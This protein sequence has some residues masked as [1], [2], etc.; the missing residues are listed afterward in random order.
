MKVMVVFGTRPE[1]IKMC[2]LILELKSR[3]SIETVVCLSGQHRDLIA[4]IIECFGIKEDYNLDIM[5]RNQTLSDIT[6]GIIEKLKEI[7]INEKPNLVLVHGDT[8]TSFA[9]ALASFYERI[10]VGHVEAGLRTYDRYSP[11]PEEINRQMIA[12]IATFHFAPTKNNRDNLIKEN[13][14]ENVYVTGNTVIDAFKTT[15]KANYIFENDLLNNLDDS[16]KYILLTAHRRENIGQPLINICNAVKKIVNNNKGFN[17]IYPVHPNPK[18]RDIVYS[19]L[20]NN[21]KILLTDPLDVLDMHNLMGKCFLIMTD[22]GGLQEEAPA[23]KKPVVVLRKETERPEAIESG[24]A[25]LAGIEEDKIY[26]TVIDIIN[27]SEIYGK[28]SNAENPYGDGNASKR[29]ADI[30]NETI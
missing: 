10:P 29:I 26:N 5:K 17:V 4:P 8:T 18:V 1:A 23:L 28:M 27:N 6:T 15:I 3:L 13:I 12:R 22:S 7:L 30:L 9:A 2:P 21:E 25:V 20:G 19:I 14:K 16:N 24:T 11:Y